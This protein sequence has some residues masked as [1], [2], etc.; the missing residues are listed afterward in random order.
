MPGLPRG[1]VHALSPSHRW[2]QWPAGAQG[3]AGRATF[4]GHEWRTGA[5]AARNVQREWDPSHSMTPNYSVHPS[6]YVDEP[7][8]IGAG[9]KIWHFCHVMAGLVL[10]SVVFWAKMCMW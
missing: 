2:A 10:G 7:C 1:A 8:S 3:V 4:P 9:T 5:I 6:A